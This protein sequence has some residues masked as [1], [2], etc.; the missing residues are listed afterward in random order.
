MAISSM[1]FRNKDEWKECLPVLMKCSFYMKEIC[2]AIYLLLKNIE[3]SM[4]NLIVFKIL[5][6]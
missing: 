1:G 4:T 3:K 2:F 6:F 5:S